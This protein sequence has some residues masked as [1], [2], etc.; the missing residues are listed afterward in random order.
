M[1]WGVPPS[2]A[3]AVGWTAL[4][5]AA[6]RLGEASNGCRCKACTRLHA[7][8]HRA[9]ATL[10]RKGAAA[11]DADERG[12]T[13]AHVAAAFDCADGVRL[14]RRARA[15]LWGEDSLGYTPL[16]IAR[17]GRRASHAVRA[18]LLMEGAVERNGG[19]V[20]VEEGLADDAR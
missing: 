6:Q 8:R 18:L 9:M 19:G 3:D 16:R 15:N 17:H 5:I 4:H 10:L 7:K 13:A 14:L 11:D 20:A 2:A 1:T 12:A